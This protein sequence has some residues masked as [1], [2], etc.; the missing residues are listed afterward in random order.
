MGKE[1]IHLRRKRKKHRKKRRKIFG[2]GKIVAG[3][4]DGRT[5]QRLDKRS[6]RKES[7]VN[8][9]LTFKIPFLGPENLLQID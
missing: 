8:L 9:F 1:N 7:K 3:R 2:E 5:G 4:M 6:S